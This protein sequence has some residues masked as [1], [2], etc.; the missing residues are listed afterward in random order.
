MQAS[1]DRSNRGTRTV[2]E[3][4]E[5]LGILIVGAK[6][7][8]RAEQFRSFV[9]SKGRSG[10]FL[11]LNAADTDALDTR[12]R[13]VV[14]FV[15]AGERIA[16]WVGQIHVCVRRL[17]VPLVVVPAK[18]DA[19]TISRLV[20]A[21][22]SAICDADATFDEILAE[23][24]A[25][26][27]VL[28]AQMRIRDKI[29]QPFIKATHIILEELSEIKVEVRSIEQ[30]RGYRFSDISAILGL[31]G[32]AE[33]ALVMSFPR[34]T[35]AILTRRL[36]MTV[37]VEPTDHMVKDCVGELVNMVAGRTRGMVADTPHSFGMSTP[38]VVFGAGHEIH[39]RPGMICF[40]VSFHTEIGDFTLQLCMSPI[41]P[42]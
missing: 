25:R 41:A 5:G 27:N 36:L 12:A 21:G 6:P 11:V 24:D 23:I 37:D 18:A 16:E 42:E 4:G 39:H 34:D 17:D 28:P 38:T 14:L 9:T 22:A 26:C 7:T 31:V 15:D 19:D 20:T 1:L 33:G 35:A 40:A 13:G 32:R 29:L 3:E 30:K 2:L 10:E 8:Q